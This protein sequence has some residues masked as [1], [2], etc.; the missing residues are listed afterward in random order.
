MHNQ[1]KHRLISLL[2]PLLLLSVLGCGQKVECDRDFYVETTGFSMLKTA[3]LIECV[4]NAG[5][6]TTGI[7]KVT[8][9][10]LDILLDSK[11]FIPVRSSLE[12]VDMP[13]KWINMIFQEIDE[14]SQYSFETEQK[15]NCNMFL[16][17]DD[18][19]LVVS[20]NY[21]DNTGN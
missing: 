14:L 8:D 17:E 16:K 1:S 2:T 9:E 18:R 11:K 13:L 12:M 15:V 4:D 6:G 7:F 19:L 3:K 20:I 21:P 10:E 5:N